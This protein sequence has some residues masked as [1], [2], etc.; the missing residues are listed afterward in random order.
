MCAM[1][2]LDKKAAAARDK[3]AAIGPDI[4]IDSFTEES[5]RHETV[6]RAADISEED[7]EQ[8][9]MAGIDTSEQEKS[10]TYIQK[11]SVAI[12][13]FSHEEGLEV[14]PIRDALEHLPWIRDYYGKLVPVDLDKYTSRAHTDL[15]DGYV[16]RALPG[17]AISFPVQAC[18]YFHKDGS[19]QNVHNI[20]IAEEGSEVHVISGCAAAAHVSRGLHIGISEFYVKKNAKLSFTMIHHWADNMV[21][22]P[23]SV[24]RVEEGGLFLSNYVSMKPIQSIQAYPTTRLEGKGSVARFYSLLVGAPGSEIDIGGRVLLKAE[25]TRAEI[26]SRAITNG[27]T[28]IARGDIVGEVPGVR[29]H[30]E[31]HGLILNGGLMHA[32]PELKGMVD[33]VEMSHEAAVGKIAQDEILYL[34]SRGLTEEEATATIVRGFLSVDI[35]GL[36]PRLKAEIDRAVELSQQEMM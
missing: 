2:D 26:V 29:G 10:G 12:Y 34:M 19:V 20:V 24:T 23:R 11:D 4:D 13:S 14:I 15:Q 28:I 9:L 3:Q 22:R 18:L 6:K 17:K 31:C 1:R 32:I 30:L 8:L 21:V 27:G 16:I 7:R 25:D 33:G 35:P 5:P 36:P